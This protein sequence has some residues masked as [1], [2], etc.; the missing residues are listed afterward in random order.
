MRNRTNKEQ[1]FKQEATEILRKFESRT[2]K[3]LE[4]FCEYLQECGKVAT[5]QLRGAES[6]VNEDIFYK[7]LIDN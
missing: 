6:F 2:Y 1:Y 4:E 3:E 5:I 7:K